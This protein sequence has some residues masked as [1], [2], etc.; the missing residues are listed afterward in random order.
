MDINQEIERLLFEGGRTV[1][2]AILFDLSHG[3]IEEIDG[4]VRE[5]NRRRNALLKLLKLIKS[6]H[7]GYF[8]TMD[9]DMDPPEEP[10][11][12]WGFQYNLSYDYH[13]IFSD[14][15]NNHDVADLLRR[16]GVLV[17]GEGV[18]EDPESCC[19]YAYF[20]TERLAQGFLDRL[21]DFMIKRARS[22]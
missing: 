7:D 12:Q 21:N 20:R 8:F 13:R 18:I 22:L 6:R 19:Y 4:H 14:C 11:Y 10:A 1:G 5:I 2:L 17:P 9:G 16:E 3:M 15:E